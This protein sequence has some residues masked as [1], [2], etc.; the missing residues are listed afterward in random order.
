MK[1]VWFVHALA[2]CWNNGNAHFLRGLGVALQ[3]MGHEVRFLEP[4]DG[5]SET[6]LVRD[7]GNRALDSFRAAFPDLRTTKYDAANVDLWQATE[8]ADLVVVHEWNPPALVNALGRM[9]ADG[10]PFVLFFQDTHHRAVSNPEEM[11]RFE[12]SGYDGALV[13]GAAIAELYRRQGWVENVWPFHEAADTTTFFPRPPNPECDLVWIG[14]WGDGER[15]AELR[16]FLIDPAGRLGLSTQLYGVRYPAPV[17]AE[18]EQRGIS[19]RGW[20][21]NHE[22]PLAFAKA[23]F[24]VHVPR[25]HY[26]HLLP[27]I[28]TIR[29]FEALA[30]GI[31]LISSPWDDCEG[32]FPHGCYLTARD[33]EEMRKLMR[34][35]IADRDLRENLRRK[36][37][38]AIRARHTCRHRAR[39]LLALAGGCQPMRKAA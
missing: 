17:L 38:A 30:C 33:G 28:P 15:S 29:V 20:L 39:E 21:A 32:L 1:I 12:L 27:G 6:N 9:R 4:R 26:A 24:T 36:G 10:A 37:L 2:S 8:G 5:W 14:N 23:R 7:H 16:E 19:W 18:L 3:E 11:R 25:R 35:V 13:F 31:P 22:A 34:A